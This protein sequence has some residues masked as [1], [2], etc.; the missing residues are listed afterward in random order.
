MDVEC[1]WP[2]S[3]HH[4][5]VFANSSFNKKMRSE[6]L[7]GVFQTIIPESEKIP[8]YVIGDPAYQLTPFCMK[9]YQ[10]CVS[11]EQVIFNNMLRLAGNPIEC[12]FGRL[13]A[14][15]SI[16]TRKMDM[17]L[18]KIPT[19]IYACFV[20]HN[21]CEH[22]KSYVDNEQVKTQMKLMKKNEEQYKN[23]PDPLFSYICGEG[24]VT[25][26][27]ITKYLLESM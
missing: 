6:K 4:S 5:K 20:L 12:A 25:R 23:L 8:K 13:K 19:I 21:Y 11:N 14:R 10:H 27:T 3:A 9:E 1:R 24:E 26:D 15:W 17:K 18:E 22:H 2:G 7:P 16:L